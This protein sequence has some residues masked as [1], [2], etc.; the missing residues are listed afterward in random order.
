MSL[1][2]LDPLILQEVQQSHQVVNRRAFVLHRGLYS[3]LPLAIAEGE[4]LHAILQELLPL[5]VQCSHVLPC[6]LLLEALLVLLGISLLLPLLR[7][8]GL[9]FLLVKRIILSLIGH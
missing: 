4:L 6:G 7:K 2:L 3:L 1:A 5:L 8:L 9:L